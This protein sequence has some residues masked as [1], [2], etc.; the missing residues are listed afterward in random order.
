MKK[1]LLAALLLSLAGSM[2][3]NAATVY[4][5]DWNSKTA[6]A[7]GS[8]SGLMDVAGTAVTVNYSGEIFNGYDQGNWGENPGS[9]TLPGVVDN[10]PT[11][12]N[13]SIQLVG[14]N[15]IHNV[16]SFSHAVLNPVIAV[17]SLGGAGVA[18]YVFDQPFTLLASGPGHWG[19]GPLT[20]SG[21]ILTGNEGNGIIQ[22]TGSYSSLSWTVP[23]PEFY[24]MFTVGA[25]AISPVPEPAS[26]LL[27]T[28]G[29]AGIAGLRRRKQRPI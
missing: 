16:L 8:A 27:I 10:F 24:H 7:P 20:A 14:G 12:V 17:Q 5:V 15:T 2:S 1:T 28:T 19:N 23:N 29:I 21:N 6:G 9:Y 11:P 26:L 13:E 22:F 18:S 4:W 3:A 25:P